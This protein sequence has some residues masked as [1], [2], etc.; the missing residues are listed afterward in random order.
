MVQGETVF[1]EISI[2][3]PPPYPWSREKLSSV[4][5]GLDAQKFG[6]YCFKSTHHVSSMQTNELRDELVEWGLR[7]C[8]S[9]ILQVL[10]LFVPGHTL[11]RRL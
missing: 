10:M 4:K 1:C 9:N 11:S 5:L 3:K 2:P 8:L 6:N 7:F